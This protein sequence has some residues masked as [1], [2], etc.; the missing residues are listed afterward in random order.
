MNHKI[1]SF[2]LSPNGYKPL[3]HLPERCHEVYIAM[4]SYGQ[5]LDLDGVE[6]ASLFKYPLMES[7]L[8]A[9]L[10]PSHVALVGE[11]G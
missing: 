7:S 6:K 11:C 1:F 4:P 2:P 5:Y 10:A 9:F 3:A 8:V